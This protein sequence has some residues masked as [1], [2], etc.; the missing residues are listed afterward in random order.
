MYIR[1]VDLGNAYFSGALGRWTYP[2]CKKPVCF[3][4]F[5][6]QT[7]AVGMLPVGA[8]ASARNGDLFDCAGQ[9]HWNYGPLSPAGGGAHAYRDVAGN[10]IDGSRVSA[11]R[12]DQPRR[13]RSLAHHSQRPRPVDDLARP[14]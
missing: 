14:C 13:D 8:L 10:G 5:H 12:V 6:Q 3:P 1:I 9:G 4:R 2:R 7:D 11:C